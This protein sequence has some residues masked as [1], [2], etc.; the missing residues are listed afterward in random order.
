MDDPGLSRVHSVYPNEQYERAKR[1]ENATQTKVARQ[2]LEVE[3]ACKHS[4]RYVP[5]G[6]PAQVF[7]ADSGSKIVD[8][9]TS[10]VYANKEILAHLGNPKKIDLIIVGSDDE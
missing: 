10:V 9:L 1:M 2:V 5:E 4:I 3:R 6:T 8:E 7:L